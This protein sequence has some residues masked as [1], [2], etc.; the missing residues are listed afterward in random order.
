MKKPAVEYSKG[1]IGRVR[2]VDDFLP[3]PDKL[4]L[5]DAP[6]TGPKRKLVSI[7][8]TKRTSPGVK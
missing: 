4:V 8:V 1:E 5:I 7:A 6:M 3:A 2:I